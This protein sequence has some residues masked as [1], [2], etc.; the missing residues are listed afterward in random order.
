MRLLKKIAP[1]AATVATTALFL[2]AT[3]A[4]ADLA[5]WRSSFPGAD[6]AIV[7]GSAAAS[8]DTLGAVE[9]AGILGT[10]SSGT[11]RT[12]TTSGGEA[13]SIDTDSTRIWLN[14]SLN[15]AKSTLTKNDLPII[16][17]DYTFSGNVDS[18]L[19]STIKLGAGAAAGG[20]NSGK[21]VFTKQPKSNNDPVMGISMGSNAATPLYNATFTSKAI[22][23]SHAD[24]E[25]SLIEFFGGAFTV[26]TATDADSLVLFKSAEEVVLTVGREA[27]TPSVT[28]T[29][30]GIEY[31][32]TLLS[33]SDTTATIDVNG[34]SKEITEGNSKKISGLEV[35]VKNVDETTSM[36]IITTLLLGS[37]KITFEAGTQVMTGSDDDP[38]DGTFVYMTGTAD[39]EVGTLTEL[40][41]A[42][43]R[44]S[45][46]EDAVLSGEPFVDPV[47][48]TFKIDFVGM[49]ENVDSTT[50]ETITIENSGDDDMSITF[51]DAEDYAG[52]LLFAHNASGTFNL[53][54][55]SNYKINVREMANLTEN[56]YIVLGNDDYGHILQVTQIYN[57]TGTDYTKDTVKIQDMWS[58]ANYDT[59]F[60]S[61]GTGKITIDG[62]QYTVNF[63]D[64]GDDGYCSFK[65]PT[66]DS[67][68]TNG[69]VFFPT[70]ETSNGAKIALVDAIELDL[71]NI[72]GAGTSMD[73]GK[74]YFPDGDGYG[75][76]IDLA[77]DDFGGYF[78]WT[79]NGVNLSDIADW[80]VNITVGDVS[81]SITRLAADANKT[82]VSFKN[83][84]GQANTLNVQDL[85]DGGHPGVLIFEE[86]DDQN[87]YRTIYVDLE[88]NA[89][90]TSTDGIGVSD[91]SFS[92]KGK[93][94]SAYYTASLATDS[95]V[96]QELDWYGTLVTTDANTAT[97]KTVTI[98]YPADQIYSQI[99]VAASGATIT[100]SG[101]SGSVGGAASAVLDTSVD[102]AL[103][104]SKNIIIMGGSGINSVA[105]D[106]LGLSS[107]TYG[108]AEE[109]VTATNVD[110]AGKAMIKLFES[111][112]APGK[113]VMLVAGFDGIDTYRAAKALVTPIAGL[114]GSEVLLNTV[115]SEATVV[116]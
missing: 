7:V 29:V 47:F 40:T 50:R 12:V 28:K 95:D 73:G 38:I 108:T 55:D 78:N 93:A 77:Y 41:I 94:N 64:S 59:V 87:Q 80:S 18:K 92:A 37:E 67:Q 33:G 25:G 63:T 88:D 52:S 105:A 75:T 71:G 107:P 101:S 81:W 82:I 10:S 36:G 4:A 16:L 70:I 9:L 99:Y 8:Y 14:T 27:A 111:K 1:I 112:Y 58:G 62:K 115:N 31:T 110:T 98:S 54:D 102:D 74:I 19:T 24:S 60:T 104:T 15:T 103:K 45:S 20:D 69:L 51:T 22:N 76:G 34:D 13:V 72:D 100:S 66:A 89:A 114:S 61:E 35:A 49:S 116:S 83:V 86:K 56:E 39:Q 57:N 90:A 97:Q 113:T 48:G 23:F 109:W 21:V 53:S 42:V 2:G 79:I 11:T 106:V 44:P 96:E 6:T 85:L 17:G 3:A 65:Y 68:A 46:S 30:G 43:Y 84:S 26:S 5:S 91:V 32:I